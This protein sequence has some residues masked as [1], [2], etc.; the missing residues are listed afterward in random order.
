M[1]P[2]ASA[3]DSFQ[4]AINIDPSNSEAHY[5][6]AVALLELGQFVAVPWAGQVLADLGADVV[7]VERSK[8][9]DDTRAWGPPFIE[10]ADGGRQQSDCGPEGSFV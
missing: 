7:K 1:Q 2:A 6:L 4:T 3:G 9:G 10:A 5:Q 8:T